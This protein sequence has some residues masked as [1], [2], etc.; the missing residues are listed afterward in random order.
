MPASAILTWAADKLLVE[1]AVQSY[2]SRCSP[3][4]FP[5]KHLI[6]FLSNKMRDF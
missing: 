1:D 4:F 6:Q 2:L 5:G 3:G